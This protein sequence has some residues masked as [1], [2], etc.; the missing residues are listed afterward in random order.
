[1]LVPSLISLII[2]TSR[3]L[4][5]SFDVF[6]YCIIFMFSRW[7]IIMFWRSCIASVFHVFWVMC[8]DLTHFIFIYCLWNF[9]TCIQCLLTMLTSLFV[10]AC[11]CAHTCRSRPGSHNCYV[12]M[13]VIALQI[14]QGI[15][16]VGVHLK[17]LLSHQGPQSGK[18]KN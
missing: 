15:E 4:K 1:M 5:S 11:M 10:W 13:S 9:H 14:I 18:C 17:L 16:V 6:F 7:G 8:C 3:L 2:F 12:F